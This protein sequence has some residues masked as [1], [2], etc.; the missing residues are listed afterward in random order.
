MSPPPKI[1]NGSIGQV[2]ITIFFFQQTDLH[3]SHYYVFL[4]ADSESDLKKIKKKLTAALSLCRRGDL[5]NFEN[6]IVG[7]KMHLW[8]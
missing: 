6:V 5:Q 8:K 2:V 4:G 1:P 7:Q 3:I